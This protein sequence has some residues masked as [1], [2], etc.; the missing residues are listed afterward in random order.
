MPKTK[1]AKP[2]P[3]LP[4]MPRVYYAVTM[5]FVWPDNWPGPRIYTTT[6]HTHSA[7]FFPLFETREEAESVAALYPGMQVIEVPIVNAVGTLEQVERE[8]RIKT[9]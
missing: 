2:R 3:P 9:H 1:P 6:G 8:N 7:G 4:A 5:L